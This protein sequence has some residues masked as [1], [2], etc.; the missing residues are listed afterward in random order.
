MARPAQF[1]KQD[2]IRRATD[3][4]WQTGYSATSISDLVDATQLK[5]G[6]IYAAF[7]SKEGLF[8]QS[9]DYY[10]QQSVAKVW[11]CL[12]QGPNPLD[13]IAKFLTSLVDEINE[14]DLQRGCF[15]V[16]TILEVAPHNEKVKDKV[17]QYIKAL[18]TC[19]F[20]AL[21]SA[22]HNGFLAADKDP[23]QLA[24]FLMVTIWGIRVMQRIST[25]K[26]AAEAMT[27]QYLKLLHD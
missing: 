27:Q 13:G 19:F 12:N 1:N 9:I 26:A 25:N 16:N 18:E 2:V 7:D 11:Q 6:S 22:R 20:N 10:G 4:F 14:D 3:T 15:L 21:Q 24:R 17:N 5:P 8:L 23:E